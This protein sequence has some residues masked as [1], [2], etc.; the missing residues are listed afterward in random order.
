MPRYDDVAVGTELP[1]LVKAPDREQLVKYAAGS[2]DFNPLHYDADFPQARTLGDN[3]VHGRMKYASLGQLVS[4]WLGSDG[5]IV[6]LG[7]NYR[8]MDMRGAK[9]V[10]RG[11]VAGKREEGGRRL[12]DLELWTESEAPDSSVQRT[13]TG[14]AT[15]EL[16]A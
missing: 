3:I 1:A 12:V 2:G 6:S 15:V 4:D 16:T 9:F 14:T 13:T 5:R 8:G 11:Q 10:C 7:A